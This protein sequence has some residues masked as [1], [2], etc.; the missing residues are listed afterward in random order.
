MNASAAQPEKAKILLV[1]D[2][3]TNL[4]MLAALLRRQGYGVKAAKDAS[5]ALQYLEKHPIDLILLD[6]NMPEINGYQLCSVLKSRAKTKQIPIIFL[7][8]S[9][10]SSAQLKAF[11]VGGA[12]FITK[13]YRIV[14]VFA[15]I[16]H[17]LA[18]ANQQEKLR[19]RNKNLEVELQQ[20]RRMEHLLLNQTSKLRQEVQQQKDMGELLRLKNIHLQR[21]ANIDKLTRLA[22]RRYF[23]HYLIQ[24]FRHCL[25]ER[26]P[27]SLVLGD[28]D[29]FKKYND[30]YGHP[31][32]D[33]CL[34][35]VAQIL[36]SIVNLPGDLVARYGGEE[37][38][39]ILPDTDQE[40]AIA[41]VESIQQALEQRRILH[42][43]SPV[44]D[45]VTMSLGGVTL[46]AELATTPKD[47]I[48]QADEALYRA[49]RNGRSQ[50]CWHE[51][52][53]SKTWV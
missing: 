2:S 38:A 13:P 20:H 43:T 50:L 12:D 11:S 30:Y 15:R 3:I 7:S 27:L 52:S 49:K 10:K 5:K 6:I 44:S 4:K 25:T 39:L 23:D 32:G 1:D 37:F 21:Q 29:H 40:A 45:Y 42:A 41:V 33:Q 51:S 24:E 18:L 19:D 14:E 35:D 26:H 22:N 48:Q 17:Q 46:L 31:Q 8:G 47:L 9:T 28:I 16:E 34:H 36:A 53:L